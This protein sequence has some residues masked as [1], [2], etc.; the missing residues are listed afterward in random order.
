MMEQPVHVVPDAATRLIRLREVFESA[1]EQPPDV[2]RAFVEEACGNDGELA[3]EVHRMLAADDGHDSFLDVPQARPEDRLHAGMVLDNTYRILGL[4]GCGG[5]GEVYRAHD[6]R[7]DREVA[8]KVLPQHL[9]VEPGSLAR[10]EREARSLARLNHQN[11][12]AIHD[13]RTWES[14]SSLVLEFVDG[15]T[16]ADRIAD[17]PMPVREAVAIARQIAAALEAAHE[18]GIVHRDLKPANVKVRTDGTV[19]VLDFGLA[20]D[21]AVERSGDQPVTT[22]ALIRHGLVVGTP[23][24][25]SPEQL[26]GR[27][28]DT[29]AD[30]WAFGAMLYEMLT[31]ERRFA[32]NNS[33]EALTAVLTA[34]MTWDR[35]PAATPRPLRHLLVRCLERDVTRRLR[36]IREARIVLEDLS[37]PRAWGPWTTALE[38][39]SPRSWRTGVYATL[40]VAAVAV[41]FW[42][43][44]LLQRTRSAPVARLVI[45]LPAGTN[46]HAVKNRA[47]IA[48]SPDGRR[49]A[50]AT[51][52][53]LFVRSLADFEAHL[54][55]GT[56]ALFNIR[57]PAF[58]PA[59]DTLLFHTGVDET[60]RT[61]PVSGGAATTIAQAPFA[62]SVSWG[63]SGIVFIQNGAHRDGP[64]GREPG[65]IMRLRPGQRTPDPLLSLNAGESVHGAQ[66]LPD[67]VSVL[68]TVTTGDTADRWDDGKIVVQ[69]SRSGVRTTVIEGGSA[70][71]YLPTG[72]LV[73][74]VRGT[75]FGVAFDPR[76]AAVTGAPV[77]LVDGVGRA[78]WRSSG[79]AHYVVSQTGTLLYLPGPPTL[80]GDVALAD[81]RGTLQRFHLPSRFYQAPRV[82]SDGKRVVVG[83]DDGK[84]AAIWV[85]DMNRP[86]A[87]RRITF[88]GNNRFP[89]WSA[90]GADVA[91]Q[92]DRDGDRSIFRQRVDGA[93]GAERL[94]R[95]ARDESHEPE[96]WSPDGKYMVFS[97]ANRTETRLW[98][99]SEHDRTVRALVD[100]PSSRRMG[101]VFSPD[102]RW[103][104]YAASTG[105]K[106][107]I[108]VEPFPP[109]GTR[110]ELERESGRRPN[111]PLWGRTGTEL[112][113][114][115][116]PGEFASVP[117][118]MQP[119]FGFGRV[120]PVVRSFGGAGTLARRPYDITPDGRFVVV[121][122]SSPEGHRT[123]S[124]LHV[125]LNW[126]NDLHARVQPK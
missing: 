54:V 45:T 37:Q 22:T 119:V 126:F 103:L 25:V 84:E 33:A 114:N 79:L 106:H 123:G 94:T 96:A 12:A 89:I 65:R 70:A 11:I 95:A 87:L 28:A 80:Q 73:Y 58:S 81:R 64:G 9:S 122:D 17:G 30:V 27:A 91:F 24:Y 97:V 66:L 124:E 49:I 59:G 69:S 6:T 18:V 20:R 110:Y 16:L 72:H 55:R 13:V 46:I 88:T 26:A 39:W 15:V 116:G 56:E 67:G 99:F 5:M 68:F 108:Y 75:L 78:D 90:D 104:A 125:V 2:R 85:F 83:T 47:T 82:S 19:K 52:A 117:V 112:F 10:L 44:H 92:S 102:G 100:L 31:G 21:L 93:G 51:P 63:P 86:S 113:F 111:H 50:Y 105:E 40:A 34:T 109:N 4:L 120:A 1:L 76:R 74:A 7:L 29:S 62:H 101:A 41:A 23:A 118:S 98:V 32:G 61:I 35:L 42:A 115:P 38:G 48:I 3:A 77:P 43:G 8:I 107:T 71:T 14:S 60:F 57:E 121:V 53:G 36:D